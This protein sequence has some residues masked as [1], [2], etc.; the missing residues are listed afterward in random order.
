MED[1]ATTF[2]IEELAYAAA[3]YLAEGKELEALNALIQ[4][5]VSFVEGYETPNDSRPDTVVL[6]S[7]RAI[8][9]SLQ[10]AY[11]PET[12]AIRVAFQVAAHNPGLQIEAKYRPLK[13]HMQAWQDKARKELPEISSIDADF[14]E[15]E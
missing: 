5:D 6:S 10:N 7:P 4:A 13:A 11:D 15:C 3:C 14:A 8:Y 12:Q 9:D 1:A 2:N